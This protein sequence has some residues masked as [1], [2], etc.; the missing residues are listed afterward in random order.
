M[1]DPIRAGNLP[2]DVAEAAWMAFILTD[3]SYRDSVAAAVAAA[4]NLAREQIAGWVEGDRVLTNAEMSGVIAEKELGL[5][6]D[7]GRV[8][9]EYAARMVRAWPQAYAASKPGGDHR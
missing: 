1:P 3:G 4:L 8:Y 6:G 9:L 7:P 2:A 5:D